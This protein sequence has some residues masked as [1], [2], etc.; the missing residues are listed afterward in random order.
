MNSE[1]ISFFWFVSMQ[2]NLDCEY[3]IARDYTD[4]LDIHNKADNLKIAD[5]LIEISKLV[6][7]VKV[8]I[9]GLKE[10]LY[11][12]NLDNVIRKLKSAGNIELSLTT[13]FFGITNIANAIPLLDKILLSIHIK[14]RTSAE[15]NQLIADINMYKQH[16]WIA[17]T[18]VDYALQQEDLE[19]IARI[20]YETGIPVEFVMYQYSTTQKN[21]SM[22]EKESIK[23]LFID[24]GER[25]CSFGYLHFYILPDGTFLHSLFCRSKTRKRDNFLADIDE[26]MPLL[27]PGEMQVCPYDYCS[28]NHNIT[29]YKEYCKACSDL[30]Y[31]RLN[32][33]SDEYRSE[34]GILRSELL[35]YKY[36]L[37][38]EKRKNQLLMKQDN[39]EIN[40]QAKI[41]IHHS[42]FY[43]HA[44]S[45]KD[46]IARLKNTY[47]W[48]IGFRITETIKLLIR[49][50]PVRSRDR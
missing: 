31:N 22:P 48:R 30:G 9:G 21:N 39:T 33:F 43:D 7:R 47:S 46:E 27:F 36:M 18:Q 8:D 32:M 40:S 3:C 49:W 16:T 37:I 6:K 38:Y 41:L 14:Q 20:E 5:K 24:S 23:K 45:D 35:H 19:N 17:L 1:F 28:C 4:E 2:C 25:F 34:L 29:F 44:K 13:N 11:V 12:K 42:E 15:I 26:L 10:P 50:V